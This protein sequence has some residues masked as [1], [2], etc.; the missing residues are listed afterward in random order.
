LSGKKHKLIRRAAREELAM[1]Q[2]RRVVPE[3]ELVVGRVHGNKS[4]RTA[5]NDPFSV[6][7]FTR[8]LKK[9]LRGV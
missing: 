3:R 8:G 5:F 6:R 7:G 1:D 9:A 2:Q 4:M